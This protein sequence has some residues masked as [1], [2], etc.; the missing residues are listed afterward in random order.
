MIALGTP[1]GNSMNRQAL[2]A[3]QIAILRKLEL[4]VYRA[5]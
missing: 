5:R 4:A 2:T 1:K 3:K